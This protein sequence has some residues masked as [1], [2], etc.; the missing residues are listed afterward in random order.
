MAAAAEV[1]IRPYPVNF[2]AIFEVT[3]GL[4]VPKRS[5][6]RQ[7]Y[8]LAELERWRDYL[9][10]PLNVHPAH[11]PA[12]DGLATRIVVA[13]R[14]KDVAGTLDFAGAIMRAV[15][16]EDRNIGEPRTVEMICE[17]LG[18][19]FATLSKHD[20]VTK[21]IAKDTQS[22]IAQG[23]FG[24]PSYI[25]RGDLFWGQDRLEFLERALQQNNP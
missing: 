18:L 20:D 21:T 7:D 9:D 14:D 22:A 2:A 12:D 8:R 23:V 1:A 13:L 6:Q 15:W 25:Y 19:D 3:G 5:K 11:W 10:I 16:S 4:P 17:E 24:A